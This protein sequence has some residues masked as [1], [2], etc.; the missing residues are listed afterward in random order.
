MKLMLIIAFVSTCG[1]WIQSSA[2]A[3]ARSMT[4]RHRVSF[5]PAMQLTPVVEAVDESLFEAVALTGITLEAALKMRCDLSGSAYAVFWANVGGTLWPVSEYVT[6]ERST[7]LATLGLTTSYVDASADF[8]KRTNGASAAVV[9]Q[10]RDS[11]DATFIGSTTAADNMANKELLVQYGIAS[12]SYERY[13][14]GVV[15]T[16]TST[17]MNWQ[18]R[19]IVPI[20]PKA[21]MRKAFEELGALYAVFWAQGPASGDDYVM[22][23]SYEAP[24]GTALLSRLRGDGDS[25]VK[26]SKSMRFQ[27]DGTGPVA[28]ASREQAEVV[29]VLGNDGIARSTVNGC[30]KTGKNVLKRAD[31]M[32]EFDLSSIHFVPVEGGVFE[33]GVPKEATL[34]GVTLDATLA[35]ECQAAGAGYATYWTRSSDGKAIV[36]GFYTTPSFKAELQGFDKYLTFPEAS[37]SFS[38]ELDDP[39]S[40]VAVVLRTRESVFIPDVGTYEKLFY[41]RDIALEYNIKSI[42]FTPV[43]GGVIEI[44]TSRGSS[45]SDWETIDDAV[46]EQIP[47]AAIERAFVKE[48]ATYSIFWTRN[49]DS[50]TYDMAANFESTGSSLNNA[51]LES[52]SSFIGECAKLH[53]PIMGSGPVAAA[54]KTGTEVVI[55]D[56]IKQPNFKRKKL[57]QEWGVGKMTMV[58]CPTG[59]LEYGTVTKD[60]RLTTTGSEFQEAARPYRRDV[61]GTEEWIKHRSTDRFR[62]SMRTLFQS[63]VFR[64]RYGEVLFTMFIATFVTAW[65]H[66]LRAKLVPQLPLLALGLNLF[67]LT[68][69]ALGLLLVFRT[70][71]CYGRWDEARKTWG[72]IINKT[73]N[74]VRQA[75]T[76]FDDS[77]PGYGS[78]RDGRRR[79]A[80]ETSAFTR[81][82]RCF[83]RG[84]SDEGNLRSELK[85]LGFTPSEIDGYMKATNR[86]V[87]ALSQISSTLRT[88]KALDPIQRSRMD[89]TLSALLDDVG[90]CERIFLTPI[91]RVYTA[92]TARFTGIWLFLLPLALTGPSLI[93]IIACGLITFFM[94]GIEELGVQIEEP[95]SVLP[96]E[97]FCDTSIGSA[98]DAMVIAEDKARIREASVELADK[99][100]M[101]DGS[102]KSASA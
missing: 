7:K 98:L 38:A 97:S 49:F 13:E 93:P 42:A 23:A 61:F 84:K 39:A 70:N 76:F 41:R 21:E 88:Q 53:L 59:V 85:G 6:P 102:L 79:V 46:K 94:L 33:Y 51:A 15:E 17:G 37:E 45:T 25:F 11:G 75:N 72:S 78:F 56:V 90:A 50:G 81:C 101:P 92:H 5:T 67:T 3:M 86:Q 44:G 96:L 95:F 52:S 82:L 30:T 60:K 58:P 74:L 54:A 91:P 10:V 89:T 57:A 18:T 24:S 77:N 16:G 1:A 20:M 71:T 64:A 14:G 40:P 43:L 47:N 32:L 9:K 34:S 48:G 63:G 28:T 4:G 68:A 65:N 66:V 27:V 73:R 87:Y 99:A 62:K 100:R 26:R 8:M 2:P 55:P 69:P 35:L 12:V 31:D 19:P 83:L 29:V 36:A 22:Q 80:A